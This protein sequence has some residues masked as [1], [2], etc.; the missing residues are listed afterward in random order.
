VLQRHRE[1]ETDLEQQLAQVAAALAQL[2]QQQSSATSTG[3][4]Q[5]Q[6]HQQLSTNNYLEDLEKCQ[7]QLL[8]EQE[9]ATR[10]RAELQAL[11]E[12]QSNELLREQES[13]E[14]IIRQLEKEMNE[15]KSQ[16][17]A[18]P[19]AADSALE[20]QNERHTQQLQEKVDAL[21]EQVVRQRETLSQ[22]HGEISALR[23][24]LTAALNRATIAEAA[25]ETP[26]P[27]PPSS[28]PVTRRRKNNEPSMRDALGGSKKLDTLD[29]C[30]SG[31]LQILRRH[32]MAR[33][34][35]V[36]YLLIL[37][38]WTLFL[39]VFHAHASTT[40][41]ISS[42]MMGAA[43]GPGNLIRGGVGGTGVGP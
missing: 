11:Q 13:K 27:P 42:D 25:A 5:Q 16:I 18:Q 8:V 20:S 2:Q 39:I 7:A 19:T 43:H 1:R 23:T 29:K 14:H 41:T 32:P 17:A 28:R 31:T 33:L 36:L 38:L 34:M 21:S 24:R 26:L 4:S 12:D 15:L 3:A 9:E 10:L 6:H 37:H 40:S 22:N 30:L 35:A